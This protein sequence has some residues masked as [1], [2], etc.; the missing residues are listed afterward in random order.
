MHNDE[1]VLTFRVNYD[2]A[3]VRADKFLAEHLNG[4]SRERLKSVFD[5]GNVTVNGSSVKPSYK[6]REG[7]TLNAIPP[8]EEILDV[9]AENI[10]LDIVYQDCDIAI[11]N[12]PAGMVVHPA[13]GN[14]TGT[15]VNALMYHLDNLS[16]IN[17]VVR[18]GIVHR[19]DKETSGLLVVAKNDEAHKALAD[20]FAV[21]SITRAYK[22]VVHGSFQ[23]E[24][25]TIDAPIGRDPY[26]RKAFCVIDKNAKRAVTHYR[27]ER[28]YSLYSLLDV[29]LETGRT[30]QIRVHMKYISHPIVGDKVYGRNTQLDKPYDGQLLHAYL[31]GFTH[32]RSG[33]YVEFKSE[34]PSRFDDLLK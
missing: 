21:H 33:E 11:V 18:P 31:L 27:V 7:D 4:F 6:L 9:K 3:S 13:N 15:M 8:V 2:D 26:D 1:N 25:G 12:K 30:H 10:P 24:I 28:D 23:K 20:Q 14:Y 17:G 5:M 22:A 19:I 16:A 29:T 32:P 34:L